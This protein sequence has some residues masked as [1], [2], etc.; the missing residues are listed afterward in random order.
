[1]HKDGFTGWGKDWFT[2]VDGKKLDH[3]QQVRFFVRP[4]GQ[5]E[6]VSQELEEK[7]PEYQGNARMTMEKYDILR[8]YNK[9]KP[10]S[11]F[12]GM[13][14]SGVS[15]QPAGKNRD[16]YYNIA[17]SEILKN[18][19]D[20]YTIGSQTVKG[21]DPTKPLF[22]H[23]GYDFPHTPVL[24]PA[25]YRE[26]FQK[27]TYEIPEFDEQELLTMPAQLKKQVMNGYSD[28]YSYKQKQAMI[29]DYF[30]YCAYG[31][32]LIGKAADDFIAYSESLNQEWM[33][34]YVHGDHGWKL[35][36]HGSISKFSPW[37][38]DAH[39]P[40]V[41]VSSD[42]KAY[43]AGKVVRDFTEFVDVAPTII[44]AAG[45]DLNEEKF[46]Y[47]DGLDLAKVAANKAPVRDYVIG[48]SHA[49]TGPRAFI[50]TGEYVFSI[51]TRP[52]KIRGENMEWAL[53]ATY[54]ELD[55]GL[56]H[57][58][59]DPHETN[60]LAFDEDYAEVARVMKEKL[61]DIVLGD[62][63]IEVAWGPRADG[64]K[65]YHSNFAPGAHDYLLE[66]PSL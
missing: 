33:I 35:N 54:E 13:I 52:N 17:L 3:R 11:D 1:M 9:R 20:K 30:A 59:L 2:E 28:H 40:I 39:N 64:T 32:D 58:T 44:A 6:W 57:C 61:L 27:H 31:D 51:Q 42:K 7:Y 25:D 43:P 26:R 24:P 15:S 5:F 19:E 47:L 46:S 37:D 16:G 14:I 12:E 56:Y 65:V 34:V 63:R 38:I 53:D 41:V 18:T 22:C 23:L 4:D 48:E 49:V 29:Q 50:R 10:K 60:N 55:P 21:I 8:H 45:A 66:L 62:N 36:D